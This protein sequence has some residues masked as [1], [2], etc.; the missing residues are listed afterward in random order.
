LTNSNSQNEKPFW[1][2]FSDE[3][4]NQLGTNLNGLLQDEAKKRL[5][6]FGPNLLK[7]KEK[8]DML[9]LLISQFR[10]PLILILI[11]A[12][13]LAF[14]LG[15][16]IN[17]GII[18]VIV[19][20][21]GLLGFW[22]ERGSTNAVQKLT[23]IVQ[24]KVSAVRGGNPDSIP[25]EDIVPGD[26]ILLAAGDIVPADCLILESKD[27]FVDEATLTGETFPSEKSAGVLPK[28][29]PIVH[30]ANSLF[31]G[32]HVISGSSRVVVVST[33]PQT[34]FGK[35]ADHLRFKP[36]ETEF[37]HGIKHF[38]YFLMIVTVRPDF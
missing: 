25:V 36:P 11:I 13:I 29:T 3:S 19:F 7:P 22:Q 5:L 10:S 37:E 21:S 12:A 24:L 26:I 20:A 38:G 16:S 2:L 17:A 23:A 27:L 4:L 34:E 32:T 1:T 31:M 6:R 30:R 15:D 18:L 14:I 33:G 35:I 28:D 9:T 8:T